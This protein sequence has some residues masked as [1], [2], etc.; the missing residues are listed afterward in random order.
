M[1]KR[2]LAF[3]L[4][5]SILISCAS[6]FRPIVP[7]SMSYGVMQSGDEISYA[8]RYNVLA[9]SKNK[10]YARKELNHGIQLLAVQVQNTGSE[11][12]VLREHAKFYM[13]DKLVLPMEP[14][15]IQQQVKQLSGLYMLWSLL[16][17]IITTCDS[18]DCSIIPLPVGLVIGIGNLGKASRAN[19]DLLAELS[20]NNILDKRIA[21]GE[22]ATGL[23]GI[24]SGSLIP[25]EIR[26]S[27]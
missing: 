3:L 22:T 15:Q 19:K 11:E 21:P 16:W 14:Q 17:V 4:I 12:I 9:E 6:Y 8:W 23:V 10:K 24:A 2:M 18:F 5:G 7:Q 13:G 1:I 20:A 27:R 25:I 26:I